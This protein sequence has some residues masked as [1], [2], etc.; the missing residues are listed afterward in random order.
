[1]PKDVV[2][3]KQSPYRNHGTPW[4]RPALLNLDDLQI[5]SI[6]GAEYRGIVQYYLLAQN[7]F[8]LHRLRWAAETSMLKTLA[9]KHR[10]TVAKTARRHKTT[11]ATPHGP[12]TCFEAREE[13]PGRKP[14]IARFGGIPLK[15]QKKAV[16]TDRQP[17]PPARPREIITRLLHGEC[18]WCHARTTVESHQVRKLADLV[19]PGREQPAWAALMT[20]MRRKTL[21]VCAPCHRA[22]HHGK[23]AANCT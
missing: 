7:V 5:I 22:I 12:R 21:I 16:I 4:F 19:R 2:T 9:A 17:A 3:A 15:R 1:V 11:I 13:R 8:I 6:Y 10:T 23:P 20:K 18:E 14:L